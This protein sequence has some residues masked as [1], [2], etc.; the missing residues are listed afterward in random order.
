MMSDVPKATVVITNPTHYAIALEYRR[1]SMTA[2]TVL[3]KGVDHVAQMIKAKAREAGVP[4]VENKPLAQALYKT[5][6]IGDVIPGPL[7]SAVA[8][9]LAQLIRLKQ[10]VL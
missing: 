1:G 7:F 2:P 5:A 3:A 9:V 4:I 6:E 8:E 10:L